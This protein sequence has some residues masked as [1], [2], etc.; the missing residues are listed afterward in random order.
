[1]KSTRPKR[2]DTHHV[3]FFVW[4]LQKNANGKDNAKTAA[5]LIRDPQFLRQLELHRYKRE[6]D[7]KRQLRNLI[8]AANHRGDPICTGNTGYFYPATPAESL[9]CLGRLASEEIDISK[10]R[11]SLHKAIAKHFR[12]VPRALTL[13]LFSME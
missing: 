8:N 2:P 6:E 1:M 7:R 13:P 10:R 9:E 4:Y 3:I 12:I 5:V 11:R